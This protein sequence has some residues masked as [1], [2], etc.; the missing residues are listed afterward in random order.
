[1]QINGD[2]DVYFIG[3]D[4]TV[5]C[6]PDDIEY[7]N[8]D[9]TGKPKTGKPYPLKICNICHLLKDNRTEFRRNQNDAKGR[10]TTRPSCI[11]CRKDIEG[12]KISSDEEKRMKKFKPKPKSIFI[13]PICSKRTIVGITAN[14][15]MDHSA[16]NGRG[17]D[18]ICD[19]CN[20]G[21]GRFKDDIV[22]LDRLSDY[23]K[24]YG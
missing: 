19:S 15:V 1:M 10:M 18:W 12:M 5:N 11:E 16:R 4:K 17:R 2:C 14:V 23:L 20:T 8:V 6:N 21:I 7:L 24:R 3:I 13:C 22:F 9:K